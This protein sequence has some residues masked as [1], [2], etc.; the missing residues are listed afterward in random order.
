M[1]PIEQLAEAALQRDDSCGIRPA[2][3]RAGWGGQSPLFD[4]FSG[5]LICGVSGEITYGGGK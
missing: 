4:G 3:C 1:D 5:E 2:P